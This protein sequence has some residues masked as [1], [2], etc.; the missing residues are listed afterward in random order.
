[1]KIRKIIKIVYLKKNSVIFF[2]EHLNV[3][4]Q[5]CL[6]SR[7]L[8]NELS[9]QIGIDLKCINTKYLFEIFIFCSYEFES[10]HF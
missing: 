5:F 1:M 10:K 7:Y 2:N 8:Q 4:H 6:K 9:F 3:V